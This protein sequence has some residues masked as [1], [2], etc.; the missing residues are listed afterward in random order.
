MAA[1]GRGGAGLRPW[2]QRALRLEPVRRFG[3]A[4][5]SPRSDTGQWPARWR[6]AAAGHHGLAADR[7]AGLTPAAPAT[8]FQLRLSHG[9]MLC[10]TLG[11]GLT[12][13]A[14][15][16]G[17][18]SQTDGLRLTSKRE[19]NMAGKRPSTRVKGW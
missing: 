19:A 18:L 10:I 1:I 12:G 14:G 6:H 5:Q 7:T 16:P 15:R 8:G 3:R 17:R 11:R 4:A 9:V 13:H 2:R